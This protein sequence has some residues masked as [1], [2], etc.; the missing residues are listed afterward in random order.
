MIG[1]VL[2][3]QNYKIQ[4]MCAAIFPPA[5][6]F[7][8]ILTFYSVRI[9]WA[10]V[11]K[12]F[13]LLSPTVTSVVWRQFCLGLWWDSFPHFVFFISIVAPTLVSSLSALRLGPVVWKLS[14]TWCK[15]RC[16]FFA[17][18]K[19][20]PLPAQMSIPLWLVWLYFG[21]AVELSLSRDVLH[22]HVITLLIWCRISWSSSS[23]CFC[24]TFL[25]VS[26][27]S[28]KPCMII[29]ILLL[30]ISSNS[31]LSSS[32]FFCT[33]SCTQWRRSWL[34]AR[35]FSAVSINSMTVSSTAT[36]L[37]LFYLSRDS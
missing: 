13:R 15:L 22:R 8:V 24:L 36:P 32:N 6:F 9:L 7:H 4:Q 31:S 16:K 11:Q 28:V 29:L 5:E 35:C 21:G 2:L 34:A 10:L 30:L 20:C 33:A 23:L 19:T 37:F 12:Q 18:A 25:S 1:F 3:I 17:C 27:S 26:T 14:W